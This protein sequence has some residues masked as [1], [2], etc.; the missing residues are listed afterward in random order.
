[1]LMSGINSARV[2]REIFELAT[3][4]EPYFSN[5]IFLSETTQ[6]GLEEI[7]KCG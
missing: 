3:W 1:M 4:A 2:L 5:D 7:R 6:S